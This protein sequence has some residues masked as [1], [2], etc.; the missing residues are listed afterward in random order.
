MA[1]KPEVVNH[2]LLITEIYSSI[3]GESTYAGRPCVFVRLTGC[4]LRCKWCDTAY[5][6]DGGTSMQISD[7]IEKILKTGIT[8]VEITGGE[9]LAQESCTELM[10][11]LVSTGLE[12]IC[13]TGGSEPIV[14]VPKEV[15]L[16]MDL[17]CPDSKMADRNLWSNLD[18]LKPQDEIKFVIAS[19]RDF[20][21]AIE[22]VRQHKLT[23]KHCVLV[24]PA[25]GLVKPDVL[26][27]WLLESGENLRF[28][29]Q[30]H[31][32][33]WSPRAKGV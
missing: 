31:K 8:L 13:E 32:Y 2:S 10:R 33:I 9:P 29:L 19:R 20:D 6:F 15:T 5:G 18:D 7:I 11:Q 25:F 28:N 12:V 14:K 23:Q 26:V 4:P 24:S 27:D 16:I 17:K 3:Q 30:Q 21:W 1:N 22:V